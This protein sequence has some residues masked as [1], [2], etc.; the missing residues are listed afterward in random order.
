MNLYID[1]AAH[2]RPVVRFDR[3]VITLWNIL[4]HEDLSRDRTTANYRMLKRIY[5]LA[6]PIPTAMKYLL[7]GALTW[8]AR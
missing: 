3:A 8:P 4:H 1:D 5:D 2:A 6:G 7:S